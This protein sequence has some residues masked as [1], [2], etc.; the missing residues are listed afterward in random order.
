MATAIRKIKG[1][2]SRLMSLDE[3]ARLLS[4]FGR[5]LLQLRLQSG[6]TPTE[7]EAKS[8]IDAGNLAKYEQGDREPGLVVM[9]IMSRCLGVKLA[10]LV[11]FD[12]SPI[13]EKS[14]EDPVALI[15]SLMAE[16]KIKSKDLAE[17]LGVSKGLVSDILNHKK[18]LSKQNIKILADYFKID[19]ALLYG[20]L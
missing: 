4:A 14:T 11:D 17:L 8:G 15:R 19:I 5:R 10:D 6:L 2:R 12:H 9:T 7:F 16:R 1:R 3:R 13:E 20:D 18:G